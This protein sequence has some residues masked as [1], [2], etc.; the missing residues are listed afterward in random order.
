MPSADVQQP[1]F[2]VIFDT[3]MRPEYYQD[4]HN[5]LA[6]PAKHL[7]RY[8]YR[9]SEMADAALTAAKAHP[10][11]SQALLVYCQAKTF[12]R[13]GPEPTGILPQNEM[14]W[15][16]TRLAEVRFLYDAGDV[17]YFDLMLG[18]YPSDNATA[19]AEIV[20]PL[21]A[22][23]AVPFQKWVAISSEEQS[24][25]VLRRGTF[26]K[27]WT[28]VTER[29]A[30]PPAQFAGDVFWR[31]VGPVTT[32]RETRQP[33][34]RTHIGAMSYFK[35][36]EGERHRFTVVSHSLRGSAAPQAQVN[37]ATAQNGPLVLESN[38]PITI[39]PHSA[40]S[41]AVKVGRSDVLDDWESTLSAMT[42]SS[43]QL[44]PLGPNV[45]FTYV[46]R[47]RV[48]KV[49]LGSLCVIL[50]SVLA[51]AQFLDLLGKGSPLAL[52]LT[53]VGGLLVT[54]GTLLLQG[55]L[56]IKF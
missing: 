56:A 15:I 47:K 8:E 28:E 20:T 6:L 22:V 55:K 13:G 7:Y 53:V 50:G 36:F 12:K 14:L 19:L 44:W 38:S 4:V 46:V 49:L 18:D 42:P 27:K 21:V 23:S 41:F 30:T 34:S 9:L 24:L 10:W 39:R 17:Y 33:N 3:C 31:L 45:T 2:W 51:L 43:R 48:W 52:G 11:P 37:L 40:F 16:G 29:L 25:D 1:G 35:A 32:V 5:I 54:V 26:H